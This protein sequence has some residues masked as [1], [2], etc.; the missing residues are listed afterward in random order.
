MFLTYLLTTVTT[1]VG[2][3]ILMLICTNLL[4]MIVRG[5]YINKQMLSIVLAKDGDTPKDVER[6]VKQFVDPKKTILFIAITLVFYYLI[7]IFLGL[8]GVIVALLIMAGRLP[9]LIWEI[10]N[11]RKIS[12]GDSY[13]GFLFYASTLLGWAAFPVLWVAI[14][15]ILT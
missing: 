1:I 15:N 14:Y 5:L 9:D 3:F 2:G 4:G 6:K 12:G 13:D 10:N 7:Y 8:L 11:G